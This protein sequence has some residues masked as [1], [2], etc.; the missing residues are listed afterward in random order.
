M[1]LAVAGDGQ[2][3]G[4]FDHACPTFGVVLVKLDT[5]RGRRNVMT[6]KQI[7]HEQQ[8]KLDTR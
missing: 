8:T 1:S 5:S 6:K 2:E 3:L 7:F 4:L